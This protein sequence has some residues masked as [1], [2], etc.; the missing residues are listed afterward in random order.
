MSD[1]NNPTRSKNAERT[2]RKFRIVALEASRNV[3]RLTDHYNLE[4]V[5]HVD[6]RVRSLFGRREE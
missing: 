6:Y 5:L 1:K 2:I 3:E 4:A